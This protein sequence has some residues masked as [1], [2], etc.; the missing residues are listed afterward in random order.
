MGGARREGDPRP[1]ASRSGVADSGRHRRE[2][3]LYRCGPR[4]AGASRFTAGLRAVRPRPPR[5][6]VRRPP[7]DAA[8]VRGLL[9]RRGIERLLPPQP[10]GGPDRA[11]HRLR[12][13]DPP[14][15]RLGPPAGHRRRRQG[16]R[17]HRLGRGH[18]DPVRRD[19]ARP[20]VG[21]DDHE[22]RGAAGDGDV[23]RGG[24][25]AGGGAGRARGH[26]PERH[27]Q[28]VHGPQHLHLSPRAVDAHRRRHHRVDL[29]GDA[30]L[31]PDLDLR[32]PHAGGGGDGGAGARLHP[33]RRHRVRPRRDQGRAGRGRLRAAAVLLLRH[34]YE[35]LHG[36]RQAPRGAAAVGRACRGA[37]RALEPP[38]TDAAHPLPDVR[39]EPHQP[40]PVQQRGADR[41]RGPCRHPRRNAVAAHQRVR[42]GARAAHRGVGANRAQHPAYPARGD[43]DHPSRRP[44]RGFVLRRVPDREP[45]RL[46]HVRSSTRSRR[47][48]A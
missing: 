37:F 3:A 40:G 14:R 1:D 13:R 18:E 15:L 22:R 30:A 34:R 5:L 25:G 36:G 29:Q 38:L 32:L 33:R 11:V 28:G 27:P 31:Q 43:R 16:G 23:H 26:R 6:D 20:D 7:L 8:P 39:G 4:R 2:A 46:R 35:L 42:R 24:R 44:A 21:V 45:R 47:S 12:S 19:P 41:G 9:H 10:G 17:G 48:G